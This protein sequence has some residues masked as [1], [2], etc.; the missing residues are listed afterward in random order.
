MAIAFVKSTGK[1]RVSSA[2]SV[3]ASFASLPSAANFIGVRTWGWHSGGTFNLP[4][5]GCSDNQSN[6]YSQAVKINKPNA[7][8]A[9]Y[10]AENIGSPS[11]TFTITVAPDDASANIIILEA[12]EYSGLV[13]SGA[14]DVTASNSGNTGEPDSGTTAA[15]AQNDELLIAVAE[16]NN[17]HPQTWT[18]PTDWTERVLET[19]NST[20]QGGQG[21]ERIISAAG[22][23]NVA[24]D[25]SGAT[26]IWA[27]C[28][29]AFKAAA[30]GG[31]TGTLVGGALV[32]ARGLIGGK[33][34]G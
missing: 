5:T 10:Y 6:T 22:T 30:G 8:V 33:L 4:A 32:D 13:T 9:I 12:S 34:V 3:A 2:G 14:L 18:T 27:A 29:A 26:A 1:A 16:S 17:S 20:Y 7:G 25:V 21:I 23:R 15:A 19:D 31:A 24:F 28:I 11:G